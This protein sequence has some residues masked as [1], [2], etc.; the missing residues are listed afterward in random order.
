MI[1]G[2]LPLAGGS[3]APGRRRRR[4]ALG[5]GGL[6]LSRPS[7][8]HEDGADD[9]G[10][11]AHSGSAF[12]ASRGLT[13]SRRSTGSASAGSAICPSAICRPARSAARRSPGCWSATARSGCSTSRP[14]GSTHGRSQEFAVADASASAGR[15]ASS[16]RRRI[17]RWGSTGPERCDSG[18]VGDLAQAFAWPPLTALFSATCGSASAPAAAR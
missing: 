16:W 12:S 9:G 8:R 2:L 3:V 1:A 15:A 17:M 14:P 6:P 4:M 7:Q 18:G 5:R 10:K 13:S 11:S